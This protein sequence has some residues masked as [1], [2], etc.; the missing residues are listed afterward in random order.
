M[1]KTTRKSA[2]TYT[3][4]EKAEFAAASAE[5]VTGLKDKID[6]TLERLS[7]L[8]AGGHSEEFLRTLNFQRRFHHYS[9]NNQFLILCQAPEAIQVAGFHTWKKVGRSVKKGAKAIYIL[10]PRTGKDRD[11]APKADGSQPLRLFG[12]KG[13]AVFADYETEG[14]PIPDF[15]RVRGDAQT[16]ANLLGYIARCGVQ[17]TWENCPGG[18]H[19]YTDGSRIV[20][21]AKR[22]EHE[23]GSATRVFMHELAHIHLH[24]QG[25]GKRP[26]DLPS[27]EIRELEADAAAYVLCG[28]AG[29]DASAQVA[30]YVKGWGGNPELL[31]TSMGRIQRAV[32]AI[33]SKL[34]ASPVITEEEPVSGEAPAHAA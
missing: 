13:V 2:R 4:E 28:F 31:K 5:R 9:L 7:E 33:L 16:H 8:L 26:E 32:S 14:D 11:A 22:C 19:G 20:L 25:E 12:F 17:T 24:F 15:M 3:A 18:V 27:R 34:D 6:A 30:D 21:D 29:V 1:T 10:M 23:P